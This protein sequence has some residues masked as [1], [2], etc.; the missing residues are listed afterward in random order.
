[1]KKQ[2]IINYTIFKNKYKQDQAWFQT[3]LDYNIKN[4]ENKIA[5]RNTFFKLRPQMDRYIFQ[6]ILLGV[7][8]SIHAYLL[9]A[10]ETIL[11]RGWK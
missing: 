3:L 7:C 10:K 6:M 1:M 5:L 2:D 11:I 8:D 4:V 9:D